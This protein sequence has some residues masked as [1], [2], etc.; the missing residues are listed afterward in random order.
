MGIPADQD[1]E[2]QVSTIS[3]FLCES[4]SEEWLPRHSVLHRVYQS[5]NSVYEQ[6]HGGLSSVFS[7]TSA[8]APQ[9]VFIF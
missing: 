3:M 2:A 5:C 1:S 8:R 7:E 9:A 6:L 4:L